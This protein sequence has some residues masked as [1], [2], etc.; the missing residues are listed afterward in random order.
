MGSSVKL[1][2]DGWGVMGDMWR[3]TCDG[4]HV[5][6]DGWRGRCRGCTGI[7]IT[8]LQKTCFSL[9]L[10]EMVAYLV[11]KGNHIVI[12]FLHL[13]KPAEHFSPELAALQCTW[14]HV[15]ASHTH[16]LYNTPLFLNWLIIQQQKGFV[17]LQLCICLVW[18]GP[19]L[20]RD[21]WHLRAAHLSRPSY[22]TARKKVKIIFQ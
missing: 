15:C 11:N 18:C 21:M 17:L 4:W 14:I 5:T 10:N 20:A 2:G 3:V 7:E 6:S 16:Y 8:S 9:M 12:H 13:Q 19:G 22:N 1:E